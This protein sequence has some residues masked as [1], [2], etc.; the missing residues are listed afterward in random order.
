MASVCAQAV[1]SR[2]AAAVA[3]ASRDRPLRL[4]GGDWGKQKSAAR[5]PVG[6]LMSTCSQG[7]HDKDANGGAFGR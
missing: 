5:V 3:A 1:L 2:W 6:S 7:P 4:D